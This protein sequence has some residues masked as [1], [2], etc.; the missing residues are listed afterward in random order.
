MRIDAAGWSKKV[1][2][3]C[4]DHGI[5]CAIRARSC[6][7][8][9]HATASSRESD[10]QPLPLSA[11]ACSGAFNLAGVSAPLRAAPVLNG[12][13]GCASGALAP[14][15]QADSRF[16]SPLPADPP[17]SGSKKAEIDRLM[18]K[19]RYSADLGETL[20]LKRAVAQFE[21]PPVAC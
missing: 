19:C 7:D 5:G 16:F 1:I 9:R 17:K 18:R 2:G 6:D 14:L 13:K 10:W 11:L 21:N 12:P 4:Q 15:A 3:H 20:P 8:I